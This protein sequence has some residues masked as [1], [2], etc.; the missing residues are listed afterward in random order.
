MTQENQ[1]NQN[2]YPFPH[3]DRE[4]ASRQLQY[5][6]RIAKD[7]HLR[8]F[9]HGND[10]RKN[11][12]KG[13]KL[14]GLC[15][16]TIAKYQQ[17]NRGVYLVVNSGG[18]EDK[19]IKQCVAIFCEW[20]DRPVAEQLLH[21]SAVGFLEPTFTI[22]SGDK[23]AQPYW[24]FDTSISVE[25]WRE[26]QLL[27]ILVMGADP[28]NKNPS[29]V[30]RLAG[31]WHVKP[32]RE[33][34]RTEIVQDSG[35]KYSFEQLR[36][37]LLS[38][39]AQASPIGVTP[40]ANRQ[41]LLGQHLFNPQVMKRDINADE[42]C[43]SF[44]RFSPALLNE[45][46]EPDAH[47]IVELIGEYLPLKQGGGDWKGDCPFCNAI[48]Q[49]I[50]KQ[51]TQTFE[52]LNCLAG[53]DADN[54][55]STQADFLRKY[56]HTFR[57]GRER[58]RYKDISVPVPESVP[59][60]ACLSKDSRDLLQCGVNM[61]GRNTNGAKLA[62]DLIG[63]ANHLQSI[64]QQFVGDARL[65]L[66]DYAARCNPPLAPKE[67]EGICQSALKDRPSPSCT[68]DGVEACIR[69]WY[70]NHHIKPNQMATGGASNNG[71]VG[72]NSGNGGSNFE[73]TSIPYEMVKG[74][75]YC[76]KTPAQLTGEL[77][78]LAATTGYQLG[79]LK[80]LAKEIE[81]EHSKSA[82]QAEESIEFAKLL[83][84]RQQELDLLRVYP[85][86][87]AKMLLSKADSDRIDPA[88]LHLYLLP[89][90]GGQLG[91]NMAIKAKDGETNRDNWLE[92]P[93]M[94]TMPVAPPSSGK[95]QTQRT[96]IGP[97]KR[98]QD[99][100]RANY[101]KALKH[102]EQLQ[103]QWQNLSAEEKSRLK[104]SNQNPEIYIEQMPAPPGIAIIEGGSPE[105]AFKR[106][107]ELGAKTGVVLAFD[108]LSRLLALDQYKTNGGDT[109]D[110]LLQAWNGPL[111]L[112][113]Q[114]VDEHKSIHL[115]QICISLTGG[116]QT[117][118][119][120]KLASDPD[121]GDGLLSRLMMGITKTPANFAVW[122]NTKVGIDEGLAGLYDHL[123]ALHHEL[124]IVAGLPDLDDEKQQPTVVLEFT[125]EAEVRWQRWWEELRRG[126][127]AFEHENPALFGYLGKMISQTLRLALVLH[128]IELKYEVL[129][130][131]LQ[132]GLATLERAIYVARWHIGQYRLLQAGT[133][134]NSLPADLAKIHAFALRKG[135]E[136]S[137]SQVQNT[138]FKRCERKPTL[139]TIRQWFET[140]A[141]SGAAALVGA[142]RDLKMI[143]KAIV[144]TVANAVGIP[145]DSAPYSDKGE[146][147]ETV[148]GQGIP[149][150]GNINSDNSDS[151]LEP[152][153]PGQSADDGSSLNSDHHQN[154]RNYRNEYEESLSNP[155]PE[156]V[157]GES[158]LSDSESESI[159]NSD[160]LSEN[161][162]IV[163]LLNDEQI[164]SWHTKLNASHTLDDA[165]NFCTSL[166]S[167]T[168]MQRNQIDE[169][170][171]PATWEWLFGLPEVIESESPA[172][173]SESEVIESESPA[174]APARSSGSPEP[175][176]VAQP[177]L[178]S[179]KA[180]LL[181]CNTLAK[182]TELKRKHK[183][184]IGMAYR[185]MTEVEQQS[186]DAIAALAVPHK[187][188]KY[189]GDEI[190]LGTERLI[191]G[192]LV[193]LDPQAQV[194]SSAR[195]ARVWAING[196]AS[197]WVRPIEVSL[198]LLQEVVKAGFK[199]TNQQDSSQQMGLI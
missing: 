175:E 15:W 48:D 64:G 32:G 147:A 11:S 3:T 25:Q 47:D 69:G 5:L 194:R 148:T 167:L 111:S 121:D 189:L 44:T 186:V 155:T 12:D 193:Y 110:V 84:Y 131:P 58:I 86:P 172:P 71:G 28:S 163:Q 192:T 107:A 10:P 92:Y 88:F 145:T 123:R 9:Y 165:T 51:R 89:I 117:A 27:L 29:R 41:V 122:S 91:A 76:A 19:D 79:G 26:V 75:L 140:M 132:I 199:E 7:A 67:V 81:A 95:S 188:F 182:L 73:Q 128:A 160:P 62:R 66:D 97:V 52:C 65:M 38:L 99:Q 154:G 4:Q 142:G 43:P 14:D 119:V 180:L 127:K 173:E 129:A 105:G 130:N 141:S 146:Q 114:R 83:N 94:W 187:V 96:M 36:S 153:D 156:P 17:D 45:T 6:G 87:L 168:L 177:T 198:S 179:L 16:D 143:A 21:W 100:A 78:N 8:F 166:D 55:A 54:Y 125:P 112:E 50:V 104:D 150:G 134:D 170:I 1:V 93:V 133:D 90:S 185:S 135:K 20:D 120:K 82:V 18:H 85:A 74:V 34:Q 171:S 33:P 183:K 176:S 46:K 144:N 24:V 59:L 178:E 124:R 102:L 174:P 106:M 139:A 118:R 57:G 196:V 61:G 35:I 157:L 31:G 136:V 63:T 109:R 149:G 108:E 137:A 98:R 2:Q 13:R 161:T 80:D 190:R 68:P 158:R 37:S 42:G 164:A 49:F 40:V 103:R 126:M 197:G 152:P 184:T 181:A 113:L 151:C 195:S 191:K 39:K 115:E 138:V 60:E 72:A 53:G 101:K 23:S 70:W 162:D 169:A 22:Y 77:V 116:M 159:G 56:Q 30:F